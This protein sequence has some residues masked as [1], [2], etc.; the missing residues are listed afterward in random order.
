MNDII[1][2]QY[3]NL[4]RESP[5]FRAFVKDIENLTD[6]ELI[7]LYGLKIDTICDFLYP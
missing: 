4:Y 6:E 5:D 2:S 1:N 3:N 7:A